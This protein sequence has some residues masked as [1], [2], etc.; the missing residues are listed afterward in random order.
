MENAQKQPIA[1]VFYILLYQSIFFMY[2]KLKYIKRFFFTILQNKVN[3]EI[4]QRIK[5]GAKKNYMLKTRV[6]ALRY[7]FGLHNFAFY[8]I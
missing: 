1:F 7:G 8:E 6:S 3:R 2:I 5:L 4:P